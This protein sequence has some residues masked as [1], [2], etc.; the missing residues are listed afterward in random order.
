MNHSLG[1]A[2]FGVGSAWFGGV[3]RTVREVARSSVE[4]LHHSKGVFEA[5]QERGVP[6][7]VPRAALENHGHVLRNRHWAR[8]AGSGNAQPQ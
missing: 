6:P 3:C 4:F 5:V 8:F 1:S 2:W 7:A